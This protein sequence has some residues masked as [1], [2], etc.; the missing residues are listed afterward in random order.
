[1]PFLKYEFT[2]ILE[3]LFTIA[4]FTVTK[5]S[6]QTEK[7]IKAKGLNLTLVTFWNLFGCKMSSIKLLKLNWTPESIPTAWVLKI[8]D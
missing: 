8:T 1:M 5:I 4:S 6:D 3:D 2:K 7:K